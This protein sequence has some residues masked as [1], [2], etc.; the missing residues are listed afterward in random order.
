MDGLITSLVGAAPAPGSETSV[1]LS[2]GDKESTR[3]YLIKGTPLMLLFMPFFL[4]GCPTFEASC[5]ATS[6]LKT[7]AICPQ[8]VLVNIN[9][10]T[11]VL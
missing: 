3:D 4:P 6:F 2:G 5:Q 8:D 1:P 7:S 10:L 9:S 11:S